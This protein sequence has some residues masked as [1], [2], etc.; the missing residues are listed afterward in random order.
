MKQEGVRKSWT[1]IFLVGI[2]TYH[3]TRWVEFHH[4]YQYS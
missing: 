2:Y 4:L 1:G 3:D